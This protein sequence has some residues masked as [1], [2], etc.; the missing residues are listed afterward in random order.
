[1]TI[2]LK[3]LEKD[4]KKLSAKFFDQVG[5]SRTVEIHD[6]HYQVTPIDEMV[7]PFKQQ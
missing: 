3:K 7:D 1:M 2:F 6:F 5:W 4:Q